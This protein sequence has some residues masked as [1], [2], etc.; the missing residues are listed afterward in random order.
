[1]A[2]TF[3]SARDVVIERGGEFVNDVG[4][5]LV[6]VLAKHTSHH[7]GWPRVPRSLRA[8]RVLDVQ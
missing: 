1:M 7:V 2:R 5:E 8:H 4:D 6:E 3:A